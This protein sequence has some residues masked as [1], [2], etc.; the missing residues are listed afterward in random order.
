MLFRCEKRIN[1][2]IS[3][4]NRI[5]AIDFRRKSTKRYTSVLLSGNVRN[6]LKRIM[7]DECNGSRVLAWT[8]CCLYIIQGNSHDLPTEEVVYGS[9]LLLLIICLT[10]GGKA[11]NNKYQQDE[12]QI[13][14]D[15][16][17]AVLCGIR[18]DGVMHERQCHRKFKLP[19]RYDMDC[20]LW[21]R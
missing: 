11:R 14:N 7:Q 8:V 3:E 16:I 20:A 15:W 19:V 2:V 18:D 17:A 4:K 9:T 1:F 21:R 13:Q 5:F 10:G 12:K 6:F